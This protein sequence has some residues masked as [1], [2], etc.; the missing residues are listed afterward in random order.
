MR[1]AT[2]HALN[3]SSVEVAISV[4]GGGWKLSIVEHLADQTL[5]YSELRRSLGDITDRVL[6]RQLR[7]LE[8][9][10]LV[11]RTVYPEVPPRVEYSL[12]ELGASLRPII[13][14]LGEWGRNWIAS[15]PD[16]PSAAAVS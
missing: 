16:S 1:D 2:L 7:E 13:V 8:S 6:T 10:G 15:R 9:D 5:R 14:H 4:V 3:V 12:T 11:Q